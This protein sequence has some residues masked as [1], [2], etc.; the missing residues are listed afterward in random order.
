MPEEE[1]LLRVVFQVHGN[2]STSRCKDHGIIVI[3]E[4]RPLE[5]EASVR[6]IADNVSQLDYRVLCELWRPLEV[7]LQAAILPTCILFVLAEPSDIN[8]LLFI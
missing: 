6:R 7:T 1:A 4:A 3:R 5:V 8:R 2:K